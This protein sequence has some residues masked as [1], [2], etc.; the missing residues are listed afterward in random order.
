MDVQV[1]ILAMIQINRKHN[2]H[3]SEVQTEKKKNKKR[4][5]GVGLKI[6]RVLY[7]RWRMAA[8][9]GSEPCLPPALL[10]Q[11]DSSSASE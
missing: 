4:G 8:L 3:T 9:A 2:S 11:T 10:P 5:A 1:Q 7:K 6:D